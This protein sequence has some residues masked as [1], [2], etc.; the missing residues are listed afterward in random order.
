[1]EPRKRLFKVWAWGT[2]A[3]LS[4]TKLQCPGSGCLLSLTVT[5]LRGTDWPGLHFPS[6]VAASLDGFGSHLLPPLLP[7]SSPPLLPVPP[8]VSIGGA[9]ES[10]NLQGGKCISV[11]HST[12]KLRTIPIIFS[13][14]TLNVSGSLPTSLPGAR[15][16]K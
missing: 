7:L 10:L 4:L 8:P 11:L 12:G 5:S 1:M 16:C 15:I 13:S 14:Q 6:G 2:W 3:F 9:Q